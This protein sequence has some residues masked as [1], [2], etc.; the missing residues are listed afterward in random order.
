M[1]SV[2]LSRHLRELAAC[3]AK[4]ARMDELSYRGVLRL[5]A[6][7]ALLRAAALARLAERML[8][9]A[10][11]L[12]A[13]ARFQSAPLA[14]WVA[15]AAIAPGL[16]V[17]SLAG[18]LLDWFGATWG[19]A[20]DMICSAT[21]VLVLGLLALT[22]ADRP[23]FLLAITALYSITSPLSAA[24]VRTLLPRLTPPGSLGRANA[25]DTGLHAVVEI[26]GPALAGILFGFAGAAPSLFVI[27]L[28]YVAAGIAVP[29]MPRS[30]EERPPHRGI[31]REAA[32]GVAYVLHHPILRGLAA[33]YALFQIGWGILLVAVPVVIIHTVGN[34]HADVLTGVLWALSG[35]AGAAGALLAGAWCRP[36]RE[37]MAMAA[38]MAATAVAIEPICARFGLPGLA[39][40]LALVGFLAGPVDVGLLT[41]RQRCTEPGWLGRVMAVSMSLNLS[42]LPIGSALGGVLL[43]W[44]VPAAFA[45]A[46]LSCLLG[47]ALSW[48]LPAN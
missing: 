24:G 35:I 43:A 4:H 5:D 8:A 39:L 20:L 12:Y 22:A 14:G 34:P 9:L 41:L 42:G 26:C 33:C 40:G 27:A 47:G 23:P 21:C 6:V 36:G 15:F 46:A 44:S 13:L 29:R 11:V 32:A 18:A 10:L 25:L 1:S 48:R 45:V 28:L 31:L 3:A 30:T 17:S 38:G 2:P 7:S 16:A 19:I 37:S